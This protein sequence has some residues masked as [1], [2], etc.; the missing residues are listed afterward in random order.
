[1]SISLK[2]VREAAVF[3]DCFKR[4]AMRRRMRDIFTRFSSRLPAAG[5]GAESEEDD[6]DEEDLDAEEEEDDEGF[7]GGGFDEAGEGFD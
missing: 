2:V 7:E 1:M 6:D 3:W 5:F 4:S